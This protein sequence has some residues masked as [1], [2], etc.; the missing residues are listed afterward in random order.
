MISEQVQII[1]RLV[2]RSH[3]LYGQDANHLIKG[4]LVHIARANA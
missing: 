3:I 4:D 2:V 1:E